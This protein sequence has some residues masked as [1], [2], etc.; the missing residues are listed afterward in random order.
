MK[1]D[2]RVFPIFVLPPNHFDKVAVNFFDNVIVLTPCCTG[3]SCLRISL[4]KWLNVTELLPYCW[5][6]HREMTNYCLAVEHGTE[7]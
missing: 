2:D 4:L 7:R 5:A 3:Q 1:E 6:W